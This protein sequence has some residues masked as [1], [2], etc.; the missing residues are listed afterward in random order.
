MV[1]ARGR[2]FEYRVMNHFKELG[3]FVIRSAGSHGA[4]DLIALKNPHKIMIQ[5]KVGRWADVEEWN[6]FL[7]V[8]EHTG[9]APFFAMNDNRKMRLFYLVDKKDGKGGKQ[10]MV[11]IDLITLR[12]AEAPDV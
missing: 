2:T 10:P 12:P 6:E 11:E 4:A 3:F 9:C 7:S 8:C 5:C 1:Y